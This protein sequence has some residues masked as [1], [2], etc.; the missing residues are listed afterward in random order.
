MEE[1]AFKILLG[2]AI[3]IGLIHT[4]IGPDHYLPFIML[5]KARGWRLRKT[6]WVTLWCGIGHVLSSVVIGLIGIA[7]GIV[8]GR[9]EGI[10]GFRGELASWALIAFGLVYC[11]WGCGMD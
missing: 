10:E 8:V 1:T 9:I 2:S 6:L 4:L 5:A 11:V 3:T 7:A